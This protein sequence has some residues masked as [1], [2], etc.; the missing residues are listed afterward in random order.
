M[1]EREAPLYAPENDRQ[2]KMDAA[3]AY[4]TAWARHAGLSDANSPGPQYRE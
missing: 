1:E 3:R 2:K 4:K